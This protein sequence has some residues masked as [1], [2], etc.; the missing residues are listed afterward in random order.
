MPPAA[1]V[2]Y[3][4]YVAV[5]PDGQHVYVTGGDDD[6]VAVFSRN[7]TTGELTFVDAEFDDVGGVDGLYRAFGVT[8]SPDG[9]HVY[10]TGGDDDAVAVFSR[11]LAGLVP[12]ASAVALTVLSL[13]LLG[14]GARRRRFC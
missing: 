14:L 1:R 11:E 6:A 7:A 12:A 3:D 13:A 4:S 5:S 2:S 8:V 10:V 9:Q